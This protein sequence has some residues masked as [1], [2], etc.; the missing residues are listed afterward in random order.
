MAAG[1]FAGEGRYVA[2]D[3]HEKSNLPSDENAEPDN[4][5]IFP[6]VNADAVLQRRSRSV[7]R[8]LR[9]CLLDNKGLLWTSE[10]R[11]DELVEVV[12]VEKDGLG[13]RIIGRIQFE[14]YPRDP[15]V[16]RK[17]SSLSQNGQAK[18]LAVSLIVTQEMVSAQDIVEGVPGI[19]RAEAVKALT[20]LAK[21][22]KLVRVAHGVYGHPDRAKPDPVDIEKKRG[23]KGRA[24]KKGD[25]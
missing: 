24:L 18:Q 1:G 15:V 4:R 9:L 17:S 10:D 13:E 20:Q 16:E 2:M 8:W 14:G 5:I 19:Q 7:E 22:G 3:E 12:V 25:A 11:I 6:N 21:E 23:R